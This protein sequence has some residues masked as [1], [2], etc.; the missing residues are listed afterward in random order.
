MSTPQLLPREAILE[1]QE[2]YKKEYGEDISFEDAQ[3]QGI[4]LLTLY[5]AVYQPIKKEWIV[6]V[7][8]K[9][10]AKHQKLKV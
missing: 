2:I 7:A 1:Y 8:K 9:I 6:E 5:Q 4:K 10:G 3:R